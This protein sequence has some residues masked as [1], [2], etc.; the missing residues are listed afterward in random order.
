MSD[1]DFTKETGRV[2]IR[3]VQQKDLDEIVEVAKVAYEYP[4]I[5]FSR[6][7]YESQ[8]KIFPEGQLCAEY[9]GKMIGSCASLIVKNED[10]AR[11]HTLDEISG[12]GFLTTHNPDGKHLYGIDVVVHPAFR[13]MKVGRRLYDERKKL[14]KQMNLKSIV[15]GGRIPNYYRYADQFTPAEYV[16]EVEKQHLYD[17][18]LTFQLKNGFK[19]RGVLSNYLKY[20]MASLKYA[21]LMEWEN[22]DYEPAEKRHDRQS[23]ASL[24]GK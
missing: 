21:V 7:Q 6:K 22:P 16:R 4:E 19:V 18:V 15:F 11:Q 2:V 23:Q 1:V 14:C 13:Q 10:Y 5:A 24:F 9:N 12:N 20:D 17:P 3:N 8:M